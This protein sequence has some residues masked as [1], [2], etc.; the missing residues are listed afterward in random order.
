ML[1]AK[2]PGFSFLPWHSPFLGP[3]DKSFSAANISI[4]LSLNMFLETTNP[5]SKLPAYGEKSSY[6][7]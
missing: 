7:K 1:E 3:E 6:P 2:K 4:R 5:E